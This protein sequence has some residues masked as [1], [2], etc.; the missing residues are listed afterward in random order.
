[1]PLVFI[2][3][4]EFTYW[5]KYLLLPFIVASVVVFALSGRKRLS[6]PKSYLIRFVAALLIALTMGLYLQSPWLATIMVSTA[7][8]L[9]FRYW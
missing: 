2:R 6:G 5:T 8:G 3:S 9:L 4:L 1:M 7:T